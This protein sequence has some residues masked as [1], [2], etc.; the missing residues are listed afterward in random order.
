MRINIDDTFVP[1]FQFFHNDVAMEYL[2]NVLENYS[3]EPL[4]LHN[5]LGDTVLD[6]LIKMIRVVANMSVDSEVGHGLG[7]TRS[8]GAVLL[9][10]LK[11]TQQLKSIK[12]VK[13]IHRKKQ[14]ILL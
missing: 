1:S 4:T 10:I 11:T 9:E 12:M 2:L 8:L 5:S 3:K 6:V 13:W 14:A 7:D